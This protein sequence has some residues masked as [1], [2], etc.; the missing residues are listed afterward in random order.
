[1]NL[2]DHQHQLSKEFVVALAG[3]LTESLSMNVTLYEVLF[4][5]DALVEEAA[6][7][8][9]LFGNACLMGGEIDG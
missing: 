5:T 9:T 4:Q 1:M 7:T 2:Q 6:H 8:A 3:D